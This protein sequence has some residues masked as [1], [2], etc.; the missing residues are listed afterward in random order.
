LQRKKRS[1]AARSKRLQ[2]ACDAAERESRYSA[3]REPI[4]GLKKTNKKRRVLARTWLACRASI[5]STRR[6]AGDIVALALEINPLIE[7][8]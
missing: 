5:G 7:K 6:T 3:F 2:A 8:N 4:G 1:D